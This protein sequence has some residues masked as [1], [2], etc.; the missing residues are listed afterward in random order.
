MILPLGALFVALLLP[1]APD[2]DVAA[3]IALYHRLDYDRAVVALGRALTKNDL[4]AEDRCAALE[5]LG[6]AY[7]V[8]GDGVNAER[9]FKNLLDEAP[10]YDVAPAL[11][12]RLKSAFARAKSA[13]IEGRRIGFEVTS[14]P[15]AKELAG[16]MIGGDPARVG[17]AVARV[18]DGH[19]SPLRCQERECRGERPEAKF[20]I[21][22]F[23]H[24]GE[25]LVTGGPYPPRIAEHDGPSW[26]VIAGVAAAAVGGGIALSLALRKGDAP[27]GS[28]GRLQLP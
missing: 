19:A 14:S 26:W 4:S 25:V 21:D 13:W 23:D 22:L 18:E 28:L 9:T 20:F 1:G 17:H 2:A 11:S 10:A 7:V 5:T 27:A 6:F 24:A 15:A 16:K 12:P 3:G 8:L